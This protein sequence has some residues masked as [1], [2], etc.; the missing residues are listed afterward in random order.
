[1]NAELKFYQWECLPLVVE[2]FC[3]QI[4]L[5]WFQSYEMRS[6]SPVWTAP[7]AF[8]VVNQMWLC[9][10]ESFCSSNFL[11]A[12]TQCVLCMLE[13]LSVIAANWLQ[14]ALEL[15]LGGDQNWSVLQRTV[16]EPQP[17]SFSKFP[18]K[19]FHCSLKNN[20]ILYGRIINWWKINRNKVCLFSVRVLKFRI[21]E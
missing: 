6:S 18:C 16:A 19:L 15:H 21:S 17:A 7:S 12:Y 10:D 5:L 3:A 11:D 14:P 9:F 13:K 1:M 20:W 4:F 2:N 8:K